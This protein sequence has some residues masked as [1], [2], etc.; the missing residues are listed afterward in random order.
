MPRYCS[1]AGCNSS[2]KTVK[3]ILHKVPEAKKKQ[4]EEEKR[5]VWKKV[6][7]V[8]ICDLHFEPHDAKRLNFNV[9]SPL[10]QQQVNEQVQNDH[11]YVNEN[12]L[13]KEEGSN[14]R[15]S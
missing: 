12:N 11:D 1:V 15:K 5:L 13:L 7:H 6:K 9:V 14:C 4:W 3:T 2:D 8:F 10:M